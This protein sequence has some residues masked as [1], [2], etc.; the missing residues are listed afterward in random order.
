MSQHKLGMS[1]FGTQLAPGPSSASLG[2]QSSAAYA[3]GRGEQGASFVMGGTPM[4]R[5]SSSTK[6]GSSEDRYGS[7]LGRDEVSLCKSKGGANHESRGPSLYRAVFGGR[8]EKIMLGLFL[9]GIALATVVYVILTVFGGGS[10]V[11]YYSR[12]VGMDENVRPMWDR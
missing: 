1:S 2:P 8:G 4:S 5:G 7:G 11:E 3:Q 9:Y 12:P 6:S 10:E